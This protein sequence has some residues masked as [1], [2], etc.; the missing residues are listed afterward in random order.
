MMFY[1]VT[2]MLAVSI[3][4]SVSSNSW[5][6]IWMGMEINLIMFLILNFK[7]KN[8]FTSESSMKYFLIQSLG[9]LFILISLST[10]N[11]IYENWPLPDMYSIPLAMM[12]KSGLAP[13]H[14]WTPPIISKMSYINIFLFLTMQKIIPLMVC[15]CS[16]MNI[17]M[18]SCLA[19]VILG[20][21]GGITQS[22]LIKIMIFSSIN[23]SGWMIMSLSQSFSLFIMFFSSYTI[24]TLVLMYWLYKTQLKWIIQIKMTDLNTKFS[25]YSTMMSLSGL[26]PL[27][28]FFPKWMIINYMFNK[29]I[30]TTSL[31][32]ITSVMMMFFYIKMAMTSMFMF[33]L[34]LKNKSN[35]KQ[36]LFFNSIPLAINCSG[37]FMF[38]ILT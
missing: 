1:M 21:L 16:W 11:L 22:S 12:L 26:P 9:S 32:I 28:G 17:L 19:N 24:L 8:M 36:L 10:N 2:P 35:L 25:I 30:Y 3:G 38:F 13:L 33:N 18:L 27:L 14:S 7:S 37:A 4:F 20:S 23:N 5:M 29:M 6:T 15:F 34:S 31:M